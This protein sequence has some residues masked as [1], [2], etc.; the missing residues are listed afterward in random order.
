M[1]QK[2]GDTT[3]ADLVVSLE[4]V[5]P[6]L[7]AAPYLIETLWCSG[8]PPVVLYYL[9]VCFF[10]FFSNQ[11]TT[12]L[13][14]KIKNPFSLCPSFFPFYCLVFILSSLL[15]FLFSLMLYTNDHSRKTRLLLLLALSGIS[16]PLNTPSRTCSHHWNN[17][18]LSHLVVNIRSLFPSSPY[19][20]LVFQNIPQR[21]LTPVSVT[22]T[23]IGR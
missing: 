20:Y 12:S 13:K 7:S 14:R 3:C 19:I 15:F 11:K 16:F 23:L 9:A 8:L 4:T 6:L 1:K 10:F 21:W 2:L 17:D 18:I 22:H 5:P